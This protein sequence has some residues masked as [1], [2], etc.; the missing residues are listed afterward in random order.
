MAQTTIHDAHWLSG[1]HIVVAGGGIAGLSFVR[2]LDRTWPVDVEEPR[3]SLYEKRE[4]KVSPEREGYSMSIR[5]DPLSGG[6]QALQK[7]CLLNETLSASITGQHGGRGAMYLWNLDW[8]PILKFKQPATPPDSLPA[9]GMR[10]ARYVLR[11]HL[12]DG[13][14]KS[15]NAHWNLSCESAENLDDGRVRVTLSNGSTTECD[16]LVAADGANSKMRAALRPEDVLQYAGAVSISGN[17]SFSESLPDLI[18][19]DHGMVLSGNGS[20]LFLSPIDEHRAVWSVSWLE[21]QP[22]GPIRG[23]DAV[24]AKDEILGEAHERGK[25]F[26]EPFQTLLNATDPRTL[27]VFN[28]VDKQP[29]NHSELA[30]N[31]IVFIG[32]SNHAVSPFAGNGANMA[33]MD[34]VDLATALRENS[35]GGTA[36]QAFDKSSMMRSKRTISSSHWTIAIFHSTGWRLALYRILLHV[37][38]FLMSF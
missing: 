36:I 32:D 16:F 2:S 13:L 18:K 33:L 11:Q 6:M 12:I 8:T 28:A 25:A 20:S 29:I 14:P 17:A 4:Q 31:A 7:L 24:Q 38:N 26:I 5:S 30:S 34:G 10:I 27:Q 15:C 23:D 19:E 3:I 22:R 37:I 1:K 35:D 9:N 21:S